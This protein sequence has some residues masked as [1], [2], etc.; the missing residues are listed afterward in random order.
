M[1]KGEGWRVEG[2]SDGDEKG[3]EGLKGMA[4]LECHKRKGLQRLAQCFLIA[5]T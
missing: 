5:T 4:K 1:W 2:V 3:G